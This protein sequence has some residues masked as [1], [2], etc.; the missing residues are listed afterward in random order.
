MVQFPSKLKY[1]AAF[2]YT[3]GHSFDSEVCKR[4]R[5]VRHAF[6]NDG[7]INGRNVINLAAATIKERI[8]EFPFLSQYLGPQVTLVPG[9]R[10]SL[11]KT[12][13]LWPAQRICQALQTSGL[14]RDIQEVLTRH[15]PVRKART[16][17]PG[18]RPNPIDHY[19]TVSISSELPFATP[20]QITLVDDFITRGSSFVGI[21]PRL[22]EAFPG[23]PI[24]CFALM[25]TQSYKAVEKVFDPLEGDIE[26]EHQWGSLNRTPR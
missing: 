8:A 6:K 11:R 17:Q 10:S 19:E 23:I 22:Y 7:F 9:P 1:A 20:T 21:F 16:A 3:P 14:C 15:T 24:Q 12:D 26:Y 13:A 18:Q 25:V 5:D 4:S 2:Q